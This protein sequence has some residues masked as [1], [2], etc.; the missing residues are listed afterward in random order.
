[1]ARSNVFT[2]LNTLSMNWS[3][4]PVS[5]CNGV[6]AVIEHWVTKTFASIILGLAMLFG[7]SENVSVAAPIVQICP[8]VQISA[9][10]IVQI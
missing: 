4:S 6:G 5:G 1:M 7:F 10:P 3:Y 8:I 9:L 2:A